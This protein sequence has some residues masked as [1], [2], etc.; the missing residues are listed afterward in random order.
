MRS[1]TVLRYLI[2]DYFSANR[3]YFDLSNNQTDLTGAT[4]AISQTRTFQIYS[5]QLE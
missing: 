3:K 5:V 4:P 2:S 1:E